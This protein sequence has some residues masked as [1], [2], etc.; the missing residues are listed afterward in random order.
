VQGSADT[1]VEETETQRL[2]TIHVGVVRNVS[3]LLTVTGVGMYL[4]VGG[5]RNFGEDKSEVKFL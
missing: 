1:R 3:E 5:G 4:N 2:K